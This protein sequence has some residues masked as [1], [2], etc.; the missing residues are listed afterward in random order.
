VVSFTPL[1]L[2]LWGKYSQYTLD[3]RLGG[4]HAAK[5]NAVR[6]CKV[7]NML[8]KVERVTF[9]SS[10]SVPREGTTSY[11]NNINRKTDLQEGSEDK[12]RYN[13][14]CDNNDSEQ[15]KV[16]VNENLIFCRYLFHYLQ[17]E[18]LSQYHTLHKWFLNISQG[19]A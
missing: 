15:M 6:L 3:R 16:R 4:P 2:C 18:K 1:P 10:F 11:R 5:H 13:P 12:N 19:S 7:S 14:A 8:H 9:T 17:F